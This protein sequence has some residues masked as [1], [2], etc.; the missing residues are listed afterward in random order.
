MMVIPI[1][2]DH[3]T[4]NGLFI[5]AVFFFFFSLKCQLAE[6]HSHLYHLL[7]LLLWAFFLIPN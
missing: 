4:V 7:E 3:C 1:K 6:A 5:D 2:T